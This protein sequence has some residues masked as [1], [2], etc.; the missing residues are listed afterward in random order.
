MTAIA[1]RRKETA[2]LYGL[3]ASL[4]P[5]EPWSSQP[6]MLEGLQ[7]H[8]D[9]TDA[10]LRERSRDFGTALNGETSLNYGGRARG[11][12]A[13]I[14]TQQAMQAELKMQM[15]SLADYVFSAYEERLLFL[16]T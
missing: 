7:W 10:L 1:R 15:S 16:K 9:A 12:T 8:F 3:D 6:S 2:N 4:L 14:A 5:T 11:T 13:D